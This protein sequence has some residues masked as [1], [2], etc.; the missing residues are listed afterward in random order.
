MELIAVD[1][2]IGA[3][4]LEPHFDLIEAAKVSLRSRLPLTDRVR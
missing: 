3:T 4:T 2:G 1:N